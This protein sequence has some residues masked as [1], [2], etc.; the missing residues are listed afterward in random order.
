MSTP[1]LLNT[2]DRL[3]HLLGATRGIARALDP[4]PVFSEQDRSNL[5]FLC[6]LVIEQQERCLQELLDL[7]QAPRTA[8]PPALEQEEQP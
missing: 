3:Y 5:Y 4:D 7:S 2:I 8:G 6:M 1:S